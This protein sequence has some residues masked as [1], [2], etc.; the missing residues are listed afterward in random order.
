[1]TLLLVFALGVVLMGALFLWAF[2][3][4]TNGE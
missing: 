2:L 1:M 3:V 4:A